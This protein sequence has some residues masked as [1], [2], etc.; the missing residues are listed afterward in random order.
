MARRGN[1]SNFWSNFGPFLKIQS[2]TLDFCDFVVNSA[3]ARRGNTSNFW[4]NFGPFLKIQSGTLDFFD[5]FVNSILRP[6]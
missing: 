3:G 4:S 1:T 6:P 5:F 2:G